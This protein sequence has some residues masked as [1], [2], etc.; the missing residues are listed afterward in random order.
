MKRNIFLLC[1]YMDQ[2]DKNSF[3]ADERQTSNSRTS[4]MKTELQFKCCIFQ[5][6]LYSTTKTKTTCRALKNN[7]DNG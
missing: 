4:H 7:S 1:F 5:S 3:R 6:S 2:F